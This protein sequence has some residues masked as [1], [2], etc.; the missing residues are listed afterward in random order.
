MSFSG[1][2]LVAK[3]EWTAF[4]VVPPTAAATIALRSIFKEVVRARLQPCR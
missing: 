2:L 4:W 3:I 1:L